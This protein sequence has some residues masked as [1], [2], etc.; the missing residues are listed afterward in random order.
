[1]EHK[2]LKRCEPKRK[3]FFFFF[4]LF[5]G[6]TSICNHLGCD[7]PEA[8][9]RIVHDLAWL[10]PFIYPFLVSLARFEYLWLLGL[11]H[12]K[13]IQANLHLLA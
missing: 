12:F 7:R 9:L 4:F 1:M 2:P 5:S 8:S 13:F 6:F 3:K 10:L 11:S